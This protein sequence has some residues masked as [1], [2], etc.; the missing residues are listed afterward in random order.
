MKVI[1]LK[2]GRYKSGIKT[3]SVSVE[4]V[5]GKKILIINDKDAQDY[6]KSGCV[7]FE[8]QEDPTKKTEKEEKKKTGQKSQR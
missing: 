1:F 4:D 8:G 7:Y 6:Q 5:I 3:V 2:L